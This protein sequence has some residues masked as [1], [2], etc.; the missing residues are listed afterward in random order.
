MYSVSSWMFIISTVLYFFLKYRRNKGV[1]TKI[2]DGGEITSYDLYD[3]FIYVYFLIYFVTIFS[4]SYGENLLTLS[5]TC[6]DNDMNY[7]T[8]I[9]GCFCGWVLIF[10]VMVGVIY[11]TSGPKINI[12]AGFSDI[13]GYYGVSTEMDN[14]FSKILYATSNLKTRLKNENSAAL[15]TAAE[16]IMKTTNSYDLLINKITPFN[17]SEWWGKLNPLK[18]DDAEEFKEE[19]FYQVLLRHNIGECFWYIY[20]GIFVCAFISYLVLKSNCVTSMK[21]LGEQMMDVPTPNSG[22]PKTSIKDF[23]TL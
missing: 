16:T 19:L 15:E 9:Y 6:Q 8:V 23:E 20:T 2:K 22:G 3:A 7:I 21:E 1:Y 10:L 17:F 5:T 14:I 11:F 4:L 18:R 13:F 12:V